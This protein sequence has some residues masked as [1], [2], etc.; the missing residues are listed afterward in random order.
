MN[1][2]DKLIV[3]GIMLASAAV[4]FAAAL[5]TQSNLLKAAVILGDLV[6]SG[7]VLQKILK[8]E[9]W[10]GV[11]MVRG[12]NGLGLMKEIGAKHP[13]A[14]RELTEFGLSFG[15][16]IPFSLYAQGRK[17]WRKVLVHL[18]LLSGFYWWLQGMPAASSWLNSF[19]LIIGVLF[20]IAAI[21]VI[22]MVS[23]AV[24]IFSSKAAL[25]SVAPVVPGITLPF[26]EGLGAIIIVAVVHEVAHGVLA[27]AEKLKVRSS[28][29]LLFGFLPIGA[30]V[31]PDEEKF[32]KLDLWK[33]RRILVAGSSSNF[34]FFLV[35]L[36]LAFG[37]TLV[38]PLFSQGVLVTDVP[39]NSSAFGLVAAGTV[40]SQLANG[41][42]VHTTTQ[43]YQ[44]ADSGKIELAGAKAIPLYSIFVSQVTDGS[45]A[46]GVLSEGERIVAFENNAV[47]STKDIQAAVASK[48]AGD[49]VKLTVEKGGQHFNEKIVLGA[50]KKM[51]V[52]LTQAPAFSVEN[53][54]VPGFELLLAIVSFLL[55]LFGITAFLNFA[56]SVVNLIPIFVT[57]GHRMVFEE[58]ASA[59]GGGHKNELKAAKITNAMGIVIMLV[60]LV[61]LGRWF[62]LI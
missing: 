48:N 62:K 13:R 18:V 37:A 4:F 35:F 6:F 11:L 38:Q 50:G 46:A 32:K 39:A 5:S 56:L 26:W 55:S 54:A 15:F 17:N 43:F 49:E 60:L 1:S 10:Y 57:D 27:A 19:A 44:A 23:S 45:P 20:G 25:S 2:K 21:G 40:F 22:S 9:G 3:A 30:F 34:Y 47:Y 58:I 16:G 28:G 14:A 41:A 42:Q 8:C 29:V 51:G 59:L 7:L 24:G 12:G 53:K 36:A 31:E 33:K 52:T 61:N